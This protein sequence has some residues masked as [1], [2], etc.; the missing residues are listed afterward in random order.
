MYELSTPPARPHLLLV[1]DVPINLEI[2]AGI[3]GNEYDLSFALSGP[4]ALDLIARNAPALVLLDVMMPDMSGHEVH[5]RLRADPATADLPVIFV[6]ADASEESELEGLEHGAE[7]YLTKPVSGPILRARVRNLLSRRQLEQALRESESLFSSL[8]TAAPVAILLL[9]HQLDCHYVNDRWAAMAGMQDAP[10]LRQQWQELLHPLDRGHILSDLA[11]SLAKDQPCSREFRLLTLTRQTWVL[12][13]A[14]PI[15]IAPRTEDKNPGLMLTLTDLT[16]RKQAEAELLVR[17]QQLE[18][19]IAAMDDLVITLDTATR[20]QTFH[21]S[22][23]LPCL[24]NPAAFIGNEYGKVLPAPMVA[25][26]DD[27]LPLLMTSHASLSQEFSLEECAKTGHYHAILTPI[28]DGAGWP[29]GFLCV[30]RDITDRKLMEQELERLATTDTLTGV[31]N[32]RR[33]IEQTEAELSRC[34]RFGTPAALLMLDIDHFKLVNDQWGHAAGDAVLCHLARLAGERLRVS[35]LFGRLGGE[36]FGI[37][38]PGTDLTGAREFAE[39]FCQFV[40]GH[41]ASTEAGEIVFSLSIGVTLCRAEDDSSDRM[42]ARADAALYR[43]K[44]GGRNRVECAPDP[45]IGQPLNGD[46]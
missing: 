21:P 45:G 6:S 8:T 1:D 32:R 30:A 15:H 3:L 39:Q 13:Q 5:R 4:E 23:S 41:S 10:A 40:H 9:D 20:I 24:N 46:R 19:L 35:D 2:L 14:A 43:A 17:E 22:R 28:K 12:A 11:D 38:L 34:H 27:A 37:L 31:A 33:F 26:L 36:E 42:F 18:T 44:A 25:M 16:E 29:T 7:D